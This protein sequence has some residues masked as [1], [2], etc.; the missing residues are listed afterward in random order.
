MMALNASCADAW[1]YAFDVGLVS[2]AVHQHGY[3]HAGLEAYLADVQQCYPID[4]LRL[5]YWP[6]Y[7]APVGQ[8]N[9]CA[10]SAYDIDMRSTK[11][12]AWSSCLPH[13]LAH[14]IGYRAHDDAHAR[15]TLD[16]SQQTPCHKSH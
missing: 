2:V 15:A 16:L 9:A 8:A 11:E 10:F 12:D 4:G 14:A 13:E 3:P 1:W 5:H 7:F 6:E